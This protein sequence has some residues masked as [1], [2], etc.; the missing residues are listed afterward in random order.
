MVSCYFRLE[1]ITTQ[2]VNGANNAPTIEGL[3]APAF[4]GL[5]TPTSGQKADCLA[6]ALRCRP[7]PLYQQND[8]NS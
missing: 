4:M 2:L 5:F 8:W 1:M 7:C 3:E 6:P